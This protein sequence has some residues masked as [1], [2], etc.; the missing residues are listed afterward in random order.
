MPNKFFNLIESYNF[1]WSD[2]SQRLQDLSPQNSYRKFFNMVLENKNNPVWRL[3]SRLNDEA[4]IFEKEL[5]R[6]SWLLETIVTAAFDSIELE[7][8]RGIVI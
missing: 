6:G 4:K 5:S 1:L 7:K 8:E 2:F 3:E